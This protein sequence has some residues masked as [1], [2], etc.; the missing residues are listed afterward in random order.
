MLKI[1]NIIDW[2]GEDGK[3]L[4]ETVESLDLSGRGQNYSIRM[5]DYLMEV[6]PYS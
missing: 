6:K 2:M 5:Q 3:E 1:L 4:I